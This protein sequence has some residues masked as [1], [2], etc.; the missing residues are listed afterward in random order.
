MKKIILALA[1]SFLAN[2][3]E[4]ASV[5]KST[6]GIQLNIVG[7]NVYNE[8]KL[9]QDLALRVEGSL[10]M[11][12]IFGGDFYPKTGFVMVPSIKIAPKWYYNIEKRFSEGKNTKNNSANFLNLELVYRPGGLVISNY[13][14]LK[15]YDSVFL[16]PNWG[17]RRSFS[18]DFNYEFN[19]GAGIGKSFLSGSKISFVPSLNFKIGYDF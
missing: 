19:V 1:A 6:T 4:K 14:H 15:V 13:D 9:N 7:L 11:V 8:S 18:E 10:D 2:A 16:I 17:I 3:Q 12:S 5:E